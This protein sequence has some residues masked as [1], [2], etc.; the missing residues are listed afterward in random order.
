MFLCSELRSDRDTTED[1]NAVQARWEFGRCATRADFAGW[2]Q[3]WGNALCQVDPTEL[4]DDLDHLDE[5][6]DELST[7]ERCADAL[8]E[9]LEEAET[10]VGSLR[11]SIK[12]LPEVL[13]AYMVDTAKLL[14]QLA[15][16]LSPA[17]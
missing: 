14:G 7:T 11:D 8:Q 15:K 1:G 16:V 2:A 12:A 5:L 6:R 4:R 17:D 13:D 3:R 10:L 9:R